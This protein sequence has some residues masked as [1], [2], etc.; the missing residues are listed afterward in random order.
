MWQIIG[1][2]HVDVSICHLLFDL[3]I[4]LQ[5][6][7][8]YLCFNQ[9]IVRPCPSIH[10]SS[11]SWLY[12]YKAASM[13]IHGLCVAIWSTH[14]I[15]PSLHLLGD[16]SWRRLKSPN[17]PC[18]LVLG[19]QTQLSCNFQGLHKSPNWSIKNTYNK[20]PVLA[21]QHEKIK[22]PSMFHWDMPCHALPVGKRLQPSQ[23]WRRNHGWR[24]P[25][26]LLYILPGMKWSKRVNF[27]SPS[28][29]LNVSG[30]FRM[31][32]PIKQIPF[33][34][35]LPVWSL[36]PKWHSKSSSHWK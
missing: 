26:Y 6:H 19:S 27:S 30:H 32:H 15:S 4:C 25:D 18:K 17:L 14:S 11:S 5:H 36:L 35:T 3:C 1:Q 10:P 28:F 7:Y 13:T 34:V 33:G 9:Y 24:Q 20:I 12:V 31:K 23:P 8:Q 16:V 2:S 22:S 29:T 21:I